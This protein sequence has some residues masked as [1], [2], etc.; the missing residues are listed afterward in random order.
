MFTK[1]Q[2]SS[3]MSSAFERLFIETQSHDDPPMN[4]FLQEKD[5]FSSEIVL[6]HQG[7]LDSIIN[8]RVLETNMKENRAVHFHEDEFRI[9]LDKYESRFLCMQD[10]LS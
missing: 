3:K 6:S 1:K 9:N 5:A 8:R 10:E 4:E 7:L 2:P